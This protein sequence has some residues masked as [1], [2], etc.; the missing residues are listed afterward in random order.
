MPDLRFSVFIPVWN[1]AEWLPGAIES[2]LGQSYGDWE[3]VIGDNASEDDLAAVAARYPDP[4]LRYHRWSTHTD[5]FENYNRT[6]TLCRGEWVQLLCADDRLHPRCLERMAAWIEAAPAPS[7]RLAMVAT[8]CRRLGLDGGPADDEYYGHRGSGAVPEGVHDAAAWVRHAV[9]LPAM[10][11]NFGSVAISRA[12]LA[13]MGGFFRPE[14]GLCSDVEL[15]LRVAAYGDVAYIAEPLL[16]YTVRGSSDRSARATQNRARGEPLTPLG[17]AFLS[18]LRAHEARRRV[19]RDE[20]AAVLRGVAWSHLQR[21]VQH[22][23]LP[24]GR[25][26]WGTLVDLARAFGYSPGTILA[27]AALGVGLVALL[28][29][30]A[31]VE[32]GRHWWTARRQHGALARLNP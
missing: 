20:R 14:V 23:Y 13:E 3:L 4:R 15:A 11:W 10:P 9:A 17:A 5:I 26:R 29:P 7:G 31:V 27:P 19:S 25:G 6:M 8:A 18:A 28:A 16:D 2:V 24:G 1:E 21:A 30:R 12:V 32:R 22:R